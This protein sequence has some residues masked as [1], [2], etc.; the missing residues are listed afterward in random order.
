ML[1][2]PYSVP[3]MLA[4]ERMGVEAGRVRVI[5]QFDE[6]AVSRMRPNMNVMLASRGEM[7]GHRDM[8]LATKRPRLAAMEALGARVLN[9][10]EFAVNGAVVEIPANRLA[11]IARLPGVKSVRPAKVYSMS[12]AAP[13]TV[14][15]LIRTVQANSNGFRGQGV[16]LAILDSGLDYTHASFAGPGTTAFYAS[17]VAGTNPTTLGA[18]NAGFFPNGPRV[19]GGYDWLGDT[20]SGAATSPG[21]LVTP[22]PNPIDNKQLSTD[23]A[24]HGTQGASAAAGLAVPSAGLRQGSAPEAM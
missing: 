9:T 13:L 5:I 16:V 3:E 19:K 12:Q 10:V 17:N 2:Q 11:A 15:E 24:G 1:P 7:L 21:N 18:H 23:F 8:L 20:W 14:P 4:T 22:D 6:A